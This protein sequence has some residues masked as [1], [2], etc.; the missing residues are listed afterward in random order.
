MKYFN[1]FGKKLSIL[2][3]QLIFL[4][5][6][7]NFAY[8]TPTL[9]CP[10]DITR[11]ISY[12]SGKVNVYWNAPSSTTSCTVSSGESCGGNSISGFFY[13]GKHNGKK[14][15]C[16][17][18]S[19]YTYSQA[20]YKAQQAGGSLVSICSYSEN[21]F[22]R[23]GMSNMS[24]PAS[25]AWIGLSDYSRE[26]KFKWSNG[27]SCGYRNWSSYEPNNEHSDGRHG[28]DYVIFDRWS[29]K[30]KDRSGSARYEFL[31]EIPCTT[32]TRPGNVSVTQIAGPSSGSAFPAGTTKI[33]YRATDEC[34]RSTTCSFNVVVNV[35]TPTCPNGAPLQTPGTP[36][37]DFNPNTQNDVIQADGCSCAGTAI[38]TCPNGTPLQTPGTPCNDFNP[39]TQNDVIQADGCSCAGTVIPTCPNG[40]P[41]QAAGTPCNDFNPN[42]QNDVIQA[43][44]CSCIGTATPTCPNGAPLQTPGTPCNDF[45]PNTQNDV[46]QADGCSCAG[47]TPPT[48]GDCSQVQISQNNGQITVAGLNSAPVSS[49]Q[50][51]DKQWKEVFKCAGNCNATENIAVSS[52][53]YRVVV[54]LY[55]ASWQPICDLQETVTVSGGGTPT[56]TCSNGA[57][58]QTPGTPC[59]DFNANTQNDV[60]QADGCSCA[61]T[62][63]PTCSNGAPLQTPGT[64]CNDF[65]ANTQ[66]DVIQ[67]DGCS[68][69]GTTPPP[70][71]DCSQVQITQNNGQITVAGLNGAPVSSVQVFDKQWK[72]VFKCAG[73]C[74]ATEN[75]AVSSGTYRVTVKF[76]SA[77]WQPI[78]DLQETVTVSGGGTPT[79]TCS[80]GAPLQT[81]GT[82]CNDYN[83]NTQND[84][85]Q[86]DGCSCAGTAAPTG[87][88]CSQV[89]ISQS[90]G[91]IVVTGLNGAP[92]TSVQV[93]DSRWKTVFRC[94]GDCDA[95]EYIPV[96]TGNYNVFVKYYTASWA[97][98]CDVNEQIKVSNYTDEQDKGD[99]SS[100][101]TQRNK[102]ISDSK[103]ISL[104]PNPV[105]E[106]LYL[107]LKPLQGKAVNIRIMNTVGQVLHTS[108]IDNVVNETFKINLNQDVPSGF[109]HVLIEANGEQPIL[110]KVVVK[111][112]R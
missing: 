40:T 70:G 47:T 21:S 64:S 22:I 75:I 79:P 28:A 17:R 105:Q 81:P 103:E 92:V 97:F 10:N 18:S 30:W 107:N 89:Q 27:S 19:D 110:K 15:Y 14:Y 77:S 1:I 101:N 96:G 38:P 42:T 56:P 69:A 57:P 52:G 88:D 9:N 51:F 34:G 23:Q 73:N 35:T 59:N 90:N 68:C 53:T 94:T 41:F 24:N 32:T 65:N 4:C 7:G 86:A 12:A 95:T 31:M 20:K 61:G 50:V 87:G 67:A 93:F 66:N 11:T 74:N 111:R 100:S 102:F 91:Q 71:S 108:K 44:G 80:N 26:G 43:D 46:I 16:S 13:L 109:Y 2:F 45:N 83:P 33:T 55:S 78:C 29:G 84:V 48:G 58:L 6:L 106:L 49:V 60:I 98:I 62:A 63:A 3:Y 82:T 104:F 54:K 8:A 25:V 72:E 99:S 112:L 36:C 5:C 85:I 39:N 76:Y 37:N